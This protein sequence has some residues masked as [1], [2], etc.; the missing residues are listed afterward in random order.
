MIKISSSQELLHQIG[1]Y[2]A[3]SIPRARRFKFVKIKS[4]GSCMAS[5]HWSINNGFKTYKFE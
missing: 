3:W 1:R 4:L 5:P 2:L